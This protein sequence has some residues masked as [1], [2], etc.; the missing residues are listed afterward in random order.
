MGTWN[1]PIFLGG[2]PQDS[3]GYA[4]TFRAAIKDS[5]FF[6]LPKAAFKGIFPPAPCCPFLS[7][8]VGTPK[9]AGVM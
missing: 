1:I 3:M 9:K 7:P 4:A 6:F 2:G 8:Y 5:C